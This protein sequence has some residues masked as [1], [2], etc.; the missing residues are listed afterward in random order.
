LLVA[1]DSPS[2]FLLRLSSAAGGGGHGVGGGGFAFVSVF[3]TASLASFD[4]F[5]F[6]L[7]KWLSFFTPNGLDSGSGSMFMS[8][9]HLA[10]G[11]GFGGTS[12]LG[13]R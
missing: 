3:V 8:L 4:S 6:V 2:L 9:D 1:L 11:L 5:S 10:P 12:F 13:Q 7:L